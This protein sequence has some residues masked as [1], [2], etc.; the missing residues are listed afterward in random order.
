MAAVLAENYQLKWHSHGAHLHS[1][2]A[3][4]YRSD[5]FTDV[6]LVTSDGRYLAGECKLLLFFVHDRYLAF[7]VKKNL[8]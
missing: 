2:V 3:M 8:L 4:L 1:S 7:E 6:T 5:N